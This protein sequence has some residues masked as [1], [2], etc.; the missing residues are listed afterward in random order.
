MRAMAPSSFGDPVDPELQQE[1]NRVYDVQKQSR[2]VAKS[3]TAEA[4][5][6]KLNR[7]KSAILAHIEDIKAALSADLRR[8]AEGPTPSE[9]YLV[10]S[11][12]DD[13]IENVARW[14]EPTP[15]T[16]S[17]MFTGV[18]E[19]VRYEARGVVL[20][21]G[22]WNFPFTL[23]FA[24]LVPIIAA[25]N[26]AIVKPNELAPEASKVSAAIIR[27]A[28][29]ESE[30]A[31]FEGGVDLANSLSELPVD[32]VFFTGSP[33]VAK[34]VMAAA[35]KHLASVT[36]ELGGKCPAIVDGTSDLVEAAAKIGSGKHDNAGQICLSPDHLWVHADVKDEFLVHY[37]A[38]VDKN[39]YVDGELNK[40]AIGKIV[41]ARNFQRVK[42]YLDDAVNRGAKL[43]GGQTDADDETVHP[44]VLLDVPMDAAIMQEEI[45]GPVLPVF[46]YTDPQKIVDHVRDSG[47]PLAMYIF[48]TNDELIETL[49]SETSSGGVTVNGWAT[50]AAEM[51]LPF[52]GVGSSGSGRYHGIHGF[53]ELSHER[54]V[55]SHPTAN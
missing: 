40:A 2:W 51:S 26:V 12:I 45:F 16:P 4:R 31:V 20:L 32:H 34:V 28:F 46:E 47:K 1:I 49:I 3:L 52:G 6:D 38:W 18:T 55:V 36:L 44:A 35:A 25:G 22:A 8:P 21:F 50:H 19:A 9:V 33:Q 5:I 14:M 43:V 11:E 53:R 17:P 41:N 37:Q 13:A 15:Y 29:D 10:L 42:G 7:L 54:A 39:L 23:L 30:V 48:S 24:P 27:E